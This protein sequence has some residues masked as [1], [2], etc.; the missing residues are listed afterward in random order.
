MIPLADASAG[1]QAAPG[2]EPELFPAQPH[3][4]PGRYYSAA[5]Y[6]ALYKCGE[7]TPLRVA[8]TLL[9]LIRAPSKYA[10]AWRWVNEDAVLASARASTERWAAGKPKGLLDG[11][12]FG[13]KDDVDAKGYVSTFGMKVDKSIPFFNK[14][15]AESEWPVA[16]LEEAG[17][18]LMGKMHM[19]EIG[20]DTTG[21]NPYNG[22]P[23]NWFNKS[24]YPGGSSSGPASALGA[25][26]AP[27]MVGTDAGGSV[28][29][30][31]A[32]NGVYG[33]KTSHNRLSTR[34]SSM[35]ITGPMAATAADLTLA[36]RTMAAP[37]ASDPV[38]SLFAPSIPPSQT[39]KKY[40]GICEPWLAAATKPVRDVI[41][42]LIAHLET[43]GY[44]V[45]P[46]SL[47]NLRLGQ[48]AHAATCL[49]E[50]VADAR[51]RV[52]GCTAHY[53]S[54]LNSP[55]RLLLAVGS[56]T[57]AHEYLAYAQ[58]RAALMR[59]LAHLFERYPGLVLLSPTAPV[60]GW[61]V[62]PGDNACGFSDGNLSMYNMTYV[63]VANTSGCP[64]VT[65]PAGYDARPDRGEGVLPVGVMGMAE[66]GAEE[67]CLQ[68]AAVVEAYVR[69]VYPGGRRRPAEWADVL[70]AA[71]DGD[72]RR[73]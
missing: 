35:C 56:Q 65:A 47:P 6:H 63:W 42:P 68:F 55:N 10:N 32:F 52:A 11:V 2:V 26:L 25:G 45:V 16:K 34:N 53:L 4:L 50:G 57:P 73:W 19:H 69:D 51:A 59:H 28:R 22:T 17:A 60:A 38:G 21:C 8:E 67:A 72:A 15:A 3:H 30:P 9:G 14:V 40:I 41:A 66:W 64:A 46:V 48:F 5:D 29:I 36:Y 27:I 33:L 61:P 12:P 58:V 70:G 24:Y 44:E 31:A 37:N 7:V 62:T 39:A 20:M 54:P 1:A 13:V 49:A 23:T 18:V 43:R 71:R